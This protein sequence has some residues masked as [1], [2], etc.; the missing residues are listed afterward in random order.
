MC[1]RPEGCVYLVHSHVTPI[2]LRWSPGLKTLVTHRRDIEGDG[3][4][5]GA[6]SLWSLGFYP[7]IYPETSRNSVFLLFQEDAPLSQSFKEISSTE[8]LDKASVG[9]FKRNF[10]QTTL[11]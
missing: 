8:P 6:A 2:L 3:G 10:K 7:E 4:G 11:S 1:K 9:N 5:G